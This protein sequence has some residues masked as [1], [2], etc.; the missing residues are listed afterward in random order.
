MYL[1][2]S[3]QPHVMPA[4]DG[5]NAVKAEPTITSH[6]PQNPSP[7]PTIGKIPLNRHG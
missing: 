4:P 2:P 5:Q 7:L 1:L 3:L 6:H